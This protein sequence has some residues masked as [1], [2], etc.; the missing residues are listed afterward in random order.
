MRTLLLS[1]QSYKVFF[2]ATENA[3][4]PQIVVK[5]KKTNQKYCFTW[6]CTVI[7]IFIT[8]YTNLIY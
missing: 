7:N 6:F 3:L 8:N 4:E 1:L 2:G 5:L